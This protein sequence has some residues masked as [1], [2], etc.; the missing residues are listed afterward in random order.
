MSVLTRREFS[1]TIAV[2]TAALSLES[3][4]LLSTDAHAA[5]T[6]EA[7]RIAGMSLTEAAQGIRSGS[8]TSSQLTQACLER[9]RL[10]RQAISQKECDVRLLEKLRED[11]WRAWGVAENKE[12]DQQAE[13]SF[14]GRWKR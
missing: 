13:E 6:S 4:G 12:V 3:S 10:Q 11:R 2:A 5:E 9:I 8:V 14:L 1:K 7:D